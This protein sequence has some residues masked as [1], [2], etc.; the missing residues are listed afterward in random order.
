MILADQLSYTT[1]A[2]FLTVFS[3]QSLAFERT[4][5]QSKAVTVSGC[6]QT[7]QQTVAHY[8]N[9]EELTFSPGTRSDRFADKAS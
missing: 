8:I 9:F 1:I 4:P 7:Q 2:G 5:G 6:S 3:R